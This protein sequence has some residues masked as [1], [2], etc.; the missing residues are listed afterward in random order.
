MAA[1]VFNQTSYSISENI[2]GLGTTSI[3]L[4]VTDADL[5]PL[6]YTI[7]GSGADD[8]RFTI[9]ATTGLLRFTAEPDFEAPNDA[10]G[11]RIYLVSISVSDGTGN[12]TT[13]TVS[14]TVGDTSPA[15]IDGTSGDDTLDAADGT[16]IE[17][18]T[19][20]GLGGNDLL[21]GGR[22]A[23]IM[24][25]GNGNDIYVVDN[26][27]DFVDEAGTSG[28]D[29]VRAAVGFTLGTNFENLLLTGFSNIN[30]TGNEQNNTITG[31]AA[32]NVLSGGGGADVLMG[33]SGSDTLDGGTGADILIGGNSS[34]T[35]IVNSV[36]DTVDEST[37]TGSNDAV[38]SS[39]DYVLGINV[40]H[41]TLT[42]TAEQGTGNTLNNT[43]IG[44]AS[45]N[46]LTGLEG[47]DRLDG[48]L[49][50]DTMIGGLG[51]DIYVISESGDI[52]DES[53]GGGTDEI[54]TIFNHT[55]DI[56]FENLRLLGTAVSGTGNSGANSITGN[57]VN[58][59]LRGLGGND[60]LD[61][62]AGND[63]LIGG[64]GDDI[65]L[66]DSSSE[67]TD[68]SGTSGI[69]EVRATVSYSLMADIEN[70]KLSGAINGT[71]NS[72]DNTITGSSSNN[73]I[74]GGSGADTM[75]GGNG[76]DIY[77]VE[78]AG[79]DV[80]EALSS[81]VDEVRTTRTYA[82]GTNVENLT[83]TGTA[84]LNGTGNSLN[85]TIKG[86]AG[87][88]TLDGGAGADTLE[89][90]A[91]NDIYFIDNVGDVV[92]EAAG[93]T[94]G[95]DI[96]N[97]IVN[98]ALLAAN[99][100]R[101]TLL[102][103]A[104]INGTGN[105]LA[106]IITGNTGS[107]TLNGGSGNDT[108]DGGTGADQLIGGSGS[109]LYIVENTGDT[110]DETEESGLDSVKASVSYSLSA[111]VENLTLIGSGPLTGTGNGSANSITGNS[112]ANTLNGGGGADILNGGA[113]VDVL[114]GGNGGDTY[115]VDS[116][117]DD[118]V[119]NINDGVDEV[120]SSVSFSLTA[121]NNVE[122]LSLTG[123]G[124]INATGSDAN[125][126]LTGN[127]GTNVLTGGAGNDTYVVNRASDSVIENAAEGTDTVIA[128]GSA[129][130]VFTLSGN[131]E[132]IS[133]GG[134][135]AVNAMG[136]GLDNVMTGNGAANVI[137]AGSGNDTLIGG[138]GA[139]TLLGGDGLDS[140]DGGFGVDNMTGG[141]GDDLYFVDN[142]ADAAN[143][144]SGA[145]TG[146]D[147]IVSSLVNF[148]LSD[149]S[150]VENLT[151]GG[152][153]AING[154]GNSGANIIVGNDAANI[155]SGG[156]GADTLNGGK[157][158]DT[159]N[160]GAGSDT[161]NGGAGIDKFVFSSASDVDGDVIA[162]FAS[163]ET[164]NLSAIDWDSIS[165]G[166]QVFTVDSDDIFVAGEIDLK[167]SGATVT[168][169]LYMDNAAG[170]DSSF[171]ISLSANVSLGD[172]AF[173]L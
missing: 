99:V 22:G 121:V 60:T 82:L 167:V 15:I 112:G 138:I 165:A 106:N 157:G 144:A 145:G 131:V 170:V 1:P 47:N 101:L 45:I 34:D 85:N 92:I 115:I 89:G 75:I 8:G 32:S 173:M 56:V 135:A 169:D 105:S 95:T 90:G 73:T 124:N 96:V 152:T 132:I 29:E 107:N 91:K 23:D 61:G 2:S 14:I 62:S 140:L 51:N 126:V 63:I 78:N 160:G 33:M 46:T 142:I 155:I 164:V 77:F 136:N 84:N 146:T 156:G 103:S 172:I 28:T 118:I 41:L 69:D 36:G 130:A 71:G 24:N 113:G 19:L 4:S 52:A 148:T 153:T 35:Y 129:G 128:T 53:S 9:N 25:G 70:L 43:I 65:Y 64:N 139:D 137:D 49:G 94:A 122:N 102:G 68:E 151:L 37:S 114:A 26:S 133:L 31:N 83:L 54:Q 67:V 88:N 97:S 74:D 109:D 17:G 141:N 11:D 120:R 12:V 59:T 168:V 104:N 81:G 39:I 57:S 93:F 20:N 18:D 72:L 50:A 149:S 42:G 158:N 7:G 143:E 21:D 87:A 5:D 80:D 30:G 55:L 166:D 116:T 110:I 6:S 159:L 161:M 48:G 134:L 38:Q 111:N 3:L 119:E 100:E 27:G 162:N 76:D 108:L 40:E 127:I 154:T 16:T 66:V 86:N 123:A 125:N 150:N 13:Q 58:N 79:D 10:N 171:T 44:N 117:T 147:T 163:G 98:I